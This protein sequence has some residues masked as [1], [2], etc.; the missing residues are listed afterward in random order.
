MPFEVSIGGADQRVSRTVE[1]LQRDLAEAQ[2]QQA[3][4]AEILRVISG[5]PTD[6]ERVFAE[7]AASAARLCDAYNAVILQVAEDDVLRVVA[8]H[9][10]IPPAETLPHTRGVVTGRAVLDRRTIQVPDLRADCDEYPG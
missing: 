6:S 8:H 5:S 7:I 4:A 3:A 10:P 9:G 2:E 1:E